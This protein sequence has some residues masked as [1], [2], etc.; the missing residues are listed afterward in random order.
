MMISAPSRE[1]VALESKGENEAES[2]DGRRDRL[3]G[4]LYSDGD[5]LGPRRGRSVP[6][7][8]RGQATLEFFSVAASTLIS[9]TRRSR[10]PRMTSSGPRVI[11][12]W[13]R[14][15]MVTGAKSPEPPTKGI[16]TGASSSLQGRRGHRLRFRRLRL[17][18]PEPAPESAPLLAGFPGGGRHDGLHLGEIGLHGALGLRSKRQGLER[19][20]LDRSLRLDRRLFSLDDHVLSLNRRLLNLDR[21]SFGR[22]GRRL[23]DRLGHRRSFEANRFRGD[24]K[25]LLDQR[26]RRR[27][28]RFRSG[29]RRRAHR[30]NRGGGAL[31]VGMGVGA[32]GL[33]T[34][35][36]VGLGVGLESVAR[37]SPS[38]TSLLSF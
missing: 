21:R 1:M 26:R 5:P 25:P 35:A 36:G 13:I 31:A 34:A 22:W 8:Q 23:S 18:A 20:S 15:S 27:R 24:G 29:G 19:G 4:P 38:R 9:S 2:T 32:V 30:R 3:P 16:S 33:A 28:G 17:A 12:T 11:G 6:N 7:C 37:V 10:A 14:R